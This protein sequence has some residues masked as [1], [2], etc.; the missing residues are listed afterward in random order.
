M[1]IDK[2]R[3][4]FTILGFT[5]SIARREKKEWSGFGT[6]LELSVSK[7]NQEGHKISYWFNVG[8]ELHSKTLKKY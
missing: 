6:V 4:F 3:K 2:S 5:F 1:Y 7:K 8:S